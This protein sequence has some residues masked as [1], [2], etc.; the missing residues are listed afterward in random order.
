[1]YET[2]RV[3]DVMSPV[4]LTIDVEQSLSEARSKMAVLDVRHLPV[5]G[6]ERVVGMLSERDIGLAAGLGLALEKVSVG[7]AMSAGP[8]IVAPDEELDMVL[9]IMAD[10]KLGSA[11]V[12]RDERVVGV[13]T[14][15]DALRLLSRIVNHIGPLVRLEIPLDT[16][17]ERL[18][19]ERVVLNSVKQSARQVAL[20]AL[21]EDETA[22]NGLS[23]RAAELDQ[24]ALRYTE[25]EEELVIPLLQR[26]PAGLV[27]ADLLRER[28]QTV[29]RQIH[30]AR[31]ALR[32]SDPEHLAYAVLNMCEV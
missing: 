31:V 6:G 22:L 27:R 20:A 14:S 30:M 26:S 3:R 21:A 10:K 23:A 18:D 9:R 8:F 2:V 19:R 1:M 17:L 11:V 13:F 16:V 7:T 15:T 25:L 12:L 28:H 32:Q 5:L 24:A 4:P 29:R